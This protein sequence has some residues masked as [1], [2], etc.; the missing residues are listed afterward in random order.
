M[1]QLP[2]DILSKKAFI[3]D[4]D[5]TLIDSMKMWSML[6]EL[7]IF[8]RSGQVATKEDL[9]KLSDLAFFENSNYEG[10][11]YHLYYQ[12]II[13]QYGLDMTVDEFKD[14]CDM[15]MMEYTINELEFKKGAVDLLK[16][17]KENGKKIAIATTTY[18]E[19]LDIY[20]KFSLKMKDEISLVDTADVIVA[21]EDVKKKKPDPE[22]YKKAVEALG[23]EPN[24]CIA[25]EDSFN[26]ALSAKQAGLEV[27]SVF[28]E[29]AEPEQDLIEKIVDCKIGSLLE[30]LEFL[31]SNYK[32][33]GEM[34]ETTNQ[35]GK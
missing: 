23:L 2:K 24:D 34:E 35:F 16:F 10:N 22:A 13:E 4:V 26:G 15:V 7:V 1:K 19:L 12:M 25:I 17:L 29:S 33:S 31:K 11:I 32:K 28:D 5:G 14:A 21:F 8:E 3:F 6:S 30:L 18:R 20:S 27:V 9:K